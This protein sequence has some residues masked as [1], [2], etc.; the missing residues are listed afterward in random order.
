[1]WLTCTQRLLLKNKKSDFISRSFF[2]SGDKTRTCDLW[3]MSPTSYQLL[4]PAI[5]FLLRTSFLNLHIFLTRTCVRL[6]ADMSLT[7]RS[8]ADPPRDIFFVRTAFLCFPSHPLCKSFYRLERNNQ[9]FF[10]FSSF[11]L[12]GRTKVEP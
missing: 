7:I 1:M 12:K 9:F 2:S 4:H 10:D 5:Y 3:V 6:L 11:L 8:L